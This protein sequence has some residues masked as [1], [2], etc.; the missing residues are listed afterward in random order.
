MTYHRTTDLKNNSC[1]PISLPSLLLTNANHLKNLMNYQ[2]LY[3]ILN[4]MLLRLPKRG[5]RAAS[6]AFQI[7]CA[8]APTQIRKWGIIMGSAASLKKFFALTYLDLVPPR[9]CSTSG[10]TAVPQR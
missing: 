4:V 2:Y 8:G 9:A 7:P 10:N 1:R 5:L 6:A 3:L